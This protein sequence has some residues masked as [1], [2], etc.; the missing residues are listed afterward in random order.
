MVVE[1]GGNYLRREKSLIARKERCSR[2]S[3]KYRESIVQKILDGDSTIAEVRQELGLSELDIL[4]WISLAYDDRGRKIKELEELI[5]VVTEGS[6]M[7]IESEDPLPDH[8]VSG[9]KNSAKQS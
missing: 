8:V 3:D 9:V 4:D 6:T 2:Y 1:S 5:Y 7:R